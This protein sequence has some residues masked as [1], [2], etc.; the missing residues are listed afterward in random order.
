MQNKR[1]VWDIETP[2]GCTLFVFYDIDT[3]SF[4]TFEISAYKNQLN[5]LIKF[6]EET[7]SCDFVGFNSLNFDGQVSRFIWDTYHEWHEFTGIEIA[8]IVSKWASDLIED[9]NIGSFP[10]YRENYLIGRHI[11]LLRIQ[12]FDNKNRRVG[13]KRLEY[14]MDAENIEEMGVHH[15]HFD[16]T[17]EEIE[18]LYYYCKNDVIET[19]HNY[20]YVIGEVEHS[21]YK[22]NN[23][24]EIREAL[25]KEFG[26]DLTNASNSKYGDEIIKIRY[27]QETKIAYEELPRKGTFRKTLKLKHGIP[28]HISFQ[29]EYLQKILKSLYKQEI[30]VDDEFSVEVHIGKQIH[31]LKLGGIHNRIKYKQYHTDDEYVI[32]DADVTGYYPRTIINNEYAPA[33]LNKKAFINAYTWIVEERERLKPQAKKDKHI[34]GIVSGYKEAAVSVYGKSGDVNNWLYDPQMRLNVCIAGEL[35]ILML[36]EALE[37]SGIECIMS[38]T[39]GAM[40]MVP[41][42]EIDLFYEICK[43]WC[44]T[45]KY[46][47]EFAEFKSIWFLTVNDYLGVKIDGEKKFK[48]DFLQDTELH[49]TKSWR[50]IRLGLAE[51]FLNGTDP[52]TFINNFN[53]IYD[54]CAR[55]SSG[56]TFTHYQISDNQQNK[57]P[58]VIRY[59]V[60]K[61]GYKIMKLVNDHVDTRARDTNVQPAT[62]PK[63]VCNR[64]HEDTHKHHLENVD[65]Q[66]YIDQINEMV[67]QLEKGKKPKKQKINPNQITLF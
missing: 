54:F 57:L 53:N 7:A 29:T 27:C 6:L 30:S 59:Y 11:D 38:N 13:L 28:N 52:E 39:D 50:V 8:P 45:T 10:P 1:Y 63:L 34:K 58:K 31:D 32:I 12:H 20:L 35:S 23:Q 56:D 48:G 16:F 42:K 15:T 41:R 36:I 60:A 49:K 9:M 62:K 64:L 18:E 2:M 66:W 25:S 17:P 67:F 19:Y 14:E 37:L 61:D 26:V 65:R 55:S 44:A 4:I 24:L 43:N 51:Y 47:L 3:H 22:G 5:G 46:Q 40:F 33:H 21:I